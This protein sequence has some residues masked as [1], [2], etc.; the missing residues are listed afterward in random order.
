[1]G[2][3]LE[4][5]WQEVGS[6]ANSFQNQAD[7]ISDSKKKLIEFNNSLDNYWK[8]TD[9]DNYKKSIESI[10]NSL[11]EEIEYLKIWQDFLLKSAK[12]YNDNVDDILVKLNEAS[13]ELGE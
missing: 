6:I 2:R 7:K 8:G 10:I 3:L 12:K 9:K 1:M 13:V 4:V 11:D 5:D